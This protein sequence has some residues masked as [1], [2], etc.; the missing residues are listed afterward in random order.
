LP[1][2]EASRDGRGVRGDF[3]EGENALV[4]LRRMVARKNLIVVL[5]C[6]R[7]KTEVLC[8]FLRQYV[9]T[10]LVSSLYHGCMV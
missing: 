4:A 6:L 3:T 2:L 10:S 7:L 9:K 8:C 5:D 1:H